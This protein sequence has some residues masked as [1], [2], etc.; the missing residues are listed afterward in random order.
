MVLEHAGVDS[1]VVGISINID[2]FRP[3][4]MSLLGRKPV[5][6]VAMVR[7]NSPYRNPDMTVGI[8]KQIYEK[9][10]SDVEIWF[11]GANDI[12]DIVDSRL[13]DFKWEQ[14]GKLT[15]PQVASVMSKADIFTDFSSHQA[16]GLTALEAMSAGCSVIVPQKGGAVEFINNYENGIV[17]DTSSFKLSLNSLEELVEDDN[18]RKKIQI[19]GIND[20]VNYYPEKVSYKILESIFGDK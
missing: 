3:R 18:L 4:H 6:I 1:N 9:Y 14:L 2:L 17:A 5:R 13:L 15:Q 10:K 12:N 7:P 20:V 11:F 19:A 8:L 16:M